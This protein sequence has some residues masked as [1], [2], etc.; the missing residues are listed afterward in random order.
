MATYVTVLDQ[1]RVLVPVPGPLP[2]DIINTNKNKNSAVDLAPSDDNS[3]YSPSARRHSE[4]SSDSLK[5]PLRDFIWGER[6][7]RN[8]L[9]HHTIPPW[10]DPLDVDIDD[11]QKL[12]LCWYGVP[13]YSSMVFA[14]AERI[15]LG[16]YMKRSHLGLK[17]GD[18]DA[19]KTW[20]KLVKWFQ[21]QSGLTMYLHPVW[22]QPTSILT[23]FSNHEIPRVTEEMWEFIGMLLDEIGYPREC[24][25][26]W[27]LDRR[28][29]Y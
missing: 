19:F 14:Y 5:L 24:E 26:K 4:Q 3:P 11:P 27:Y 10:L 18:L 7:V 25:L 6:V 15:R 29:E 16:V 8:A 13:F 12:P 20:P 21:D 23:F 28:L 22:G 17:P 9:P 2:V 1:E